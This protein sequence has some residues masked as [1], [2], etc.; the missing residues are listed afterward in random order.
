[1]HNCA[2]LY[3]VYTVYRYRTTGT[4]SCDFTHLNNTHLNLDL[5]V[6]ERQVLCQVQ[7]ILATVA[8]KV[9]LEETIDTTEQPHDLPVTRSHKKN[10][11]VTLK[12]PLYITDKFVICIK[13]NNVHMYLLFLASTNNNSFGLQYIEQNLNHLK[14]KTNTYT[15]KM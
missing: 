7:F 10:M 12:E 14:I 9:C 13:Q 5:F 15:S 2:H 11:C 6:E 3:L 1:M 4:C 8:K